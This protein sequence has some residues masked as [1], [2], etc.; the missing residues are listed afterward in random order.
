MHTT[1]SSCCVHSHVDRVGLQ[2]S[3]AEIIGV[4]LLHT[5][6]TLSDH[7]RSC[8]AVIVPHLGP[9]VSGHAATASD[10]CGRA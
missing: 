6:I 5:V 1:I 2:R 9:A 10:A 3:I 7:V 4:V 8:R